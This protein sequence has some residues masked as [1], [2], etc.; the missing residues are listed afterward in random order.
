MKLR[1]HAFVLVALSSVAALPVHAEE[2]ESLLLSGFEEP[3]IDQWRSNND[4]YPPF[5]SELDPEKVK[6]GTSSGKWEAGPQSNP[7]LFFKETPA[8]WSGY[9]GMSFWLYSENGNGQ[10]LNITVNSGEGYYL[11]RVNVDWQGWNHV[12][13][14]FSEFS[15]PRKVA[16]WNDVSGLMFSLKGYGQEEPLPDTLLYFDD[17]RLIRR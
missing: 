11:H 3:I 4:K 6:E 9:E 2:E 8:D 5:V 1:L 12:V 16:G 15:A 10:Q 7:W 14:P 13:I 17:L